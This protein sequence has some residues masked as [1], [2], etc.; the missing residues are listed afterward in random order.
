MNLELEKII[1]DYFEDWFNGGPEECIATKPNLC[2]VSIEDC[3]EIARRFYN[4]G[5]ISE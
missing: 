5:R 4:L 1:E 2:F 3:Q